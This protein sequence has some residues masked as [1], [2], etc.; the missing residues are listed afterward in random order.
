MTRD[1][2]GIIYRQFKAFPPHYYAAV[3]YVE[4]FFVALMP[5]YA[6]RASCARDFSRLLSRRLAA[7]RIAGATC[8][9]SV[10][11]ASRRHGHMSWSMP[12]HLM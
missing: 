4:R 3:A 10:A 1:K 6:R 5:S 11:G 8:R 2:I 12:Q 9:S 7:R